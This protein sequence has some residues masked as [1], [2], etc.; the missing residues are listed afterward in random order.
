M[1]LDGRNEW[2]PPTAGLAESATAP[3]ERTR[4]TM[5]C[6]LQDLVN[7]LPA[8][9]V[10][11]TRAVDAVTTAYAAALALSDYAVAVRHSHP[12]PIS[13]SRVTSSSSAATTCLHSTTT[14]THGVAARQPPH[15]AAPR[16]VGRR[17]ATGCGSPSADAA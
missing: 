7:H 12:R 17:P 15:P 9:A 8:Q 13:N 10:A 3:A 14:H 4:S 11:A 2:P 16:G 5:P 6:P 1:T